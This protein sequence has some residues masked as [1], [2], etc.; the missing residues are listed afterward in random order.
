MDCYKDEKKI[1]DDESPSGRQKP[2]EVSPFSIESI[3]G[4][5]ACS[6]LPPRHPAGQ[7]QIFPDNLPGIEVLPSVSHSV[8][9][10][11]I[12]NNL[13]YSTILYGSW[14]AAASKTQA[15]FGLQ[16]PK[17]IGRR[18]RKPGMDRKPRQAYSAK[19]L[20]RLES[21]FNTDKYLSVSKRM[22][23]SKALNLT[24]VQI[25]TWFQNRR[26]KWKKQLASRLKIAHR[27]TPIFFPHQYSPVFSH[28]SSFYMSN[29]LTCP[30]PDSPDPMKPLSMSQDNL[31]M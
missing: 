20:E 19:Q 22:E 18:S 29:P 27:Q 6:P 1:V 7:E 30:I 21:E 12:Y 5:R 2:L 9:S 4:P 16:A 13:Q 14:F 11:N 31:D 24:E 17:P 8:P 10:S 25:K 26:T 23:L 15:L 28:S 3:L